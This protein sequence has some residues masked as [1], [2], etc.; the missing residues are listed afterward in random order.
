MNVRIRIVISHRKRQIFMAA[1]DAIIIPAQESAN[2][3]ARAGDLVMLVTMGASAVAALAIGHYFFDGMFALYCSGALLT[4]GAVTFALARGTLASR[5]VLTAGNVAFIIL[6]IQLGQGM[7]EF[8]FGIFM[9]LG[10]LLVYRD[11]RVI[12]FAAGLIAVHHV[13][14]DRLMALHF[15]VFCTPAANLPKMIL[16]ASYVVVQTA[17]EIFL[18]IQLREAAVETA[19]LAAIV[20]NV[21]RDSRVC[22]DVAILPVSAPTAIIL[23][24]AL[25]KVSAAI[26]EVSTSAASIERASHDITQGN[27][28][29]SQR[30]GEQAV[31]LQQTAAS[32]T[33]L[34]GAVG[35][36]AQT[37]SQATAL[38][39][40]ASSA[41]A[42]GGAVVERVVVTMA[43]I[44]QSSR[45]IAEIVTM[46]DAI[47]FQT[48]IL[49]LNAAVEAARAGEEGRGFAVVATEVRMLA[50][51]SAAAS[52]DIRQL[53]DA[54]GSKVALGLEQ[55]SA[56]G[57]S[58]RNIVA[59]SRRVSQLLGEISSAADDQTTDITQIGAAVAQ[60]DMVTQQNAT[61]V[62]ESA[63]AAKSLGEQASRLN[64]V[65]NRFALAA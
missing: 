46:I 34:T 31:S 62:D 61:L 27:D 24:E 17:I 56:A 59:Q 47:A 58:M 2:G 50:N 10:L 14:F 55:A 52:K 60:L 21:D 32:M 54:S 53:I 15:G 44:A 35:N 36:T 9:F 45:K 33:T 12:V 23:K 41:A 18:A 22:L 38:A 7:V 3:I 6:H 42:E 13:L 20:R 65:V 29:L 28:D 8:H 26:S 25:L 57:S 4:I 39:G 43:D 1:I 49:A 19:E 64:A 11:W 37:A 5:C 40:S 16:H 51:R 63:L 48:N 30:T